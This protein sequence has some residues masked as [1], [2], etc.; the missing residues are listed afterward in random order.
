[1][2]RNVGNGRNDVFPLIRTNATHA[3]QYLSQAS[4]NITCHSILF[5][6]EQLCCSAEHLIIFR[7]LEHLV[8][9][10]PHKFKAQVINNIYACV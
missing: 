10:S 3:F 5:F 2:A 9:D 7:H 6:E 1:M 8:V 4:Q